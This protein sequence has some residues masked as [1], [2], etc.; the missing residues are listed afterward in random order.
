MDLGFQIMAVTSKQSGHIGSLESCAWNVTDRKKKKKLSK[1]YVSKTI[2]SAYQGMK[3]ETGAEMQHITALVIL[4]PPSLFLT[5]SLLI[6]R[7]G[8]QECFIAA[9]EVMWKR[10]AEVSA[11]FLSGISFNSDES[12]AAQEAVDLATE[13]SKLCY[14]N[15]H[16]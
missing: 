4:P 6:L 8:P 16:I 14:E 5:L 15:K 12:S 10:E 7:V 2:L 11:F 13:K 3:W 9:F 1:S